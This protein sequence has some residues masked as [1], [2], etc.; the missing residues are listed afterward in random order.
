MDLLL[1][2]VIDEF[3]WSKRLI[4]AGRNEKGRGNNNSV[5]TCTFITGNIVIE[6]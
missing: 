3:E 1:L 2:Q 4:S 5:C 6:S